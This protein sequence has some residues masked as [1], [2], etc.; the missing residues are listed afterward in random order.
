M[1]VWSKAIY[2]ALLST[3]MAKNVKQQWPLQVWRSGRPALQAVSSTN[4]VNLASHLLFVRYVLN[5]KSMIAFISVNI[6]EH[7]ALHIWG[8]HFERCW[9]LGFAAIFWGG[10]ISRD[11]ARTMK[12]L[13]CVCCKVWRGT[14]NA[15]TESFVSTFLNRT[16]AFSG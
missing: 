1:L 12:T 5:G 3:D 9:W 8:S 13:M 7:V 6:Y 16:T 15:W 11:G 2:S 4:T 14:W 10:G